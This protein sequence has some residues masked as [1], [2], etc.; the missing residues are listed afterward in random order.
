MKDKLLKLGRHSFVYGVGSALGLA[1]GF[2]LIPLYTNVLSTEE[3]GVLELITRTADILMLVM[4]MGVRQAFMRFYFDHDDPDWHKTVVGT[5]LALILTSSITICLLFYPFRGLVA[6]WLFKA[7]TL[8]TLFVF[9]IIWLPLELLASIG[10][11]SLQIQM[12]SV[13]YV[14][15]NFIKFILVITSNIL[16]VYIYRKGIV[17]ILITNIW[18]AGLIGLSFLVLLI[19]WSKFKISFDLGKRLLKFGAPY[20]PTAVFLFIICNSDRYF[21]SMFSSLHAV[22]IYA[23]G[24][25]IGM[26]GIAIVMDA[27]G[28]IWAPFL[29]DN[30]N[31]PDGSALIS[32]TFLLYTLLSVSVGLTIS[33]LSPIVIPLISDKAFHDSHK[34]VPLIC[35]ASILWGMAS[36]ADAGILIAKKTF[37]KPM[38]FGSAAMVALGGNLLLVP[39]LGSLGAAIALVLTFL[40]LLIINYAMANKFYRIVI[41]YKKMLLIFSSAVMVYIFSTHVLGF[42]QNSQYI[43]ICSISS[44][45][46]YPVILWFGGLFSYDEKSSIK[47]SFLKKISFSVKS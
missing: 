24:Y 44:L 36:L 26:F 3:Y 18:V 43:K 15:I 29:F 7:S 19:K 30:Y 11:T 14:T 33:V 13:R 28:K 12:K 39:K 27:F 22:G 10:M 8:Q 21:L 6:H 45:F 17:G 5:T 9:M 41:E 4:F 1:G 47:N 31:K 37:Y 32:K 38:I 34:V 35:L 23:L 2:I 16:L 42:A 46:I 20:L 40:A 25:K